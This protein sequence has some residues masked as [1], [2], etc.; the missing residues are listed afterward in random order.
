MIAV[1]CDIVYL[2]RVARLVSRYP[3]GCTGFNRLISKFMHE[4]EIK[5]VKSLDN[6][7]LISYIAGTWA[8]KEAGL[9]AI[10]S[11]VPVPVPPPAI[12]IYTKLLY[13]SRNL[14]GGPVLNIDM[15][16]LDLKS[17]CEKYLSQCEFLSS[18]S[19]DQDYLMAY[20]ILK[21]KR[22]ENAT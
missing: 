20:T 3:P 2:P 22:D 6:K 21:R 8:L 16:A 15:Q 4:K 14:H 12:H 13:R 10:H 7:A 5:H 19:H 17:P 18:I 1:G 11:G 9:K